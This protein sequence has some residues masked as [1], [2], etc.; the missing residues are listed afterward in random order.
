MSTGEGEEG[1]KVIVMHAL[2]TSRPV[3]AVTVGEIGP[4]GDMQSAYLT[5]EQ[6][7]QLAARLIE[8]AKEAE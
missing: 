5:A 7:R 8:A 1:M 4:Y 2:G 6:A 3:V